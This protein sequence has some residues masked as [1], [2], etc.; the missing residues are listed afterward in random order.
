MLPERLFV[1]G[2]NDACWLLDDKPVDGTEWLY[3]CY[4]IEQ[5]LNS[6]QCFEYDAALSEILSSR[7]RV[8]DCANLPGDY[9]WHLTCER[10][11]EALIKVLL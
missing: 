9:L 1:N 6:E 5:K 7:T 8:C 10:R 4:L 3:V 11:A 2:N